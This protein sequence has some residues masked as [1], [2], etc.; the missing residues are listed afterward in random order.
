M[1]GGAN[2]E[3]NRKLL[4]LGAVFICAQTSAPIF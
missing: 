1:G 3:I 4:A 2:A